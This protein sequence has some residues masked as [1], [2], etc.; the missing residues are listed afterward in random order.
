MVDPLTEHHFKPFEVSAVHIIYV[1][2]G[3]FVVLFAS[4]SLFVKEKLYLGEAP[5]A[6]ILGIIVGE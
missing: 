5:I 1:G 3:A 4:L 6:A 2:F